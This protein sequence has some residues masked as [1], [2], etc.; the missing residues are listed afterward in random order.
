MLTCRGALS[1]VFDQPISNALG[2]MWALRLL[3]LIIARLHRVVFSIN[4]PITAANAIIAISLFL[5]LALVVTI[6]VVVMANGIIAVI[7]AASVMRI[8]SPAAC[9]FVM[10][11]VSTGTKTRMVMAMINHH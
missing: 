9:V 8:M 7:Y 2:M 4:A 6:A 5:Q 10:G 1:I 11:N 3:A